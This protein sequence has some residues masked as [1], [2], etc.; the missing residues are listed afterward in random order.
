VSSNASWLHVSPLGSIT[1]DANSTNSSRAGSVVIASV[2][3]TVNQVGVLLCTGFTVT[4]TDFKNLKNDATT[5]SVTVT[6][7]SPAS[8]A[9]GSFTAS[10]NSSWLHVSDNSGSIAVDANN[11]GSN[12]DGSV[13]IAGT[14]VTVEQKKN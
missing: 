8:C 7:S 4:P 11:T 6:G 10:S 9:G 14:T 1:V 5:L 13:V 12:R 3:V 2:T